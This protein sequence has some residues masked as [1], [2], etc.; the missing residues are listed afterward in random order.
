MIEELRIRSLGVID[1]AV[2][3]FDPGFTV[4]TGETGAGKTMVVTGLGLLLGARS[5]AGQVRHG[6]TQANVEG[7]IIIDSEGPVASRIVE[8]GGSVDEDVAVIA[9]SVSAQG[10]SRAHVG[11][12]GAPIG[13]LVDLAA[14]LAV[15]HGQADQQRLL[16]PARQRE[17]LDAYADAHDLRGRYQTAFE[18]HDQAQRRLAELVEQRQSRLQEADAV[19]FGLAEIEKVGPQAGEDLALRIEEQRLSHADELFGAAGAVRQL[20]DNSDN[21]SDVGSSSINAQTADARR[22]LDSVREHDEVLAKLADRV[23]EL[24]YLA[25]DLASDLTTYLDGIE[26]DPL[27]LAAVSERRAALSQ[28]TRKYGQTIDEVLAWFEQAAARLHELDATDH[29]VDVLSR[30]VETLRQKLAG[31]GLLLSVARQTAASELAQAVTDELADLAMPHAALTIAV[32]QTEDEDGL[33]L[34][35]GRR[36]RFGSQGLDEVAILL[37][38]HADAPAQSLARGASGGELSRVMLALEAVL[39]GADAVPTFV[40]D[41]VDAGVGGKAAVEVGRRLA[42]LARS[43]QVIVV[44]HLPQVAAFADRHLVVSKSS[45]GVVTSSDVV[46]VSTKDRAKELARMLA[47]LEESALGQA[48]AEELLEMAASERRIP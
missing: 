14:D 45:D 19:R 25:T 26:V 35:D 31:T 39:A 40:F 3:E 7:T 15:V 48:H 29:D 38:P 16:E 34:D 24:G 44:T 28:L 11:G 33:E 47:G 43:A 30:Q 2:L 36:V 23:A 4:V 1:D 20:L 27:R 37:Q 13:V 5:D 41:E 10:R 8:A 22:L 32:E 18:E 12:A 9:R 42:R 21:E 46:A 6:A 17:L